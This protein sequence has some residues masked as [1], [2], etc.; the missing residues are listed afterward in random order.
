VDFFAQYA[1]TVIAQNADGTLELQPDDPRLPGLS[2]VPIRYGVPGLAAK[3]APASRVLV[4]FEAGSPAHPIATVWES[5]SIISLTFDGNPA[6]P[7]PIARA[8]IDTCGP[9]PI[10][11][12]NLKVKG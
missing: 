10:L 3:V 2:G 5:A 11:G 12:G 6:T 4:G 8:A 1:A 7:M 9:W